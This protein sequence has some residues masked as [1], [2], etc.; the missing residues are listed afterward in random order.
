MNNQ[1]TELI[2][3]GIFWKNSSEDLVNLLKEA[4]VQCISALE[5]GGY[6]EEVLTSDVGALRELADWFSCFIEVT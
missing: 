6:G 3:V 1:Q 5:Q 2:R 4:D